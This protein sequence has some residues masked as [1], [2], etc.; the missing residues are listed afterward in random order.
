MF[1]KFGDYMYS[2]LFTPIKKIKQTANQFYIFFKVV[3]RLFD[4]TKTDIFR[5]REESMV[6]SASEIMLPEHGRDRDMSRLKGEST[7]GYRTRLSMKAIISEKAGTLEAIYLVL[8]SFHLKR[9]DVLPLYKTD[10]SRWA[11]FLVCLIYELD[12]PVIDV[13]VLRGEVRKVKPASAKDNYLIRLQSSISMGQATCLNRIVIFHK[14]QWYKNAVWDG[15]IQWNG[16]KQWDSSQ[17]N[18]PIQLIIKMQCQLSIS[19]AAEL[20]QRYHYR[21]WDGGSYWGGTKKW[22]AQIIKE[23][24]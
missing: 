24:I 2:L 15:N 11:E 13:R 4:D 9:Y 17:G 10:K 1:E 3:G 8:N 5:V 22:D 19:H 20:T 12:V 16:E 23:V 6:A 14:M 18:H 7:E 21:T